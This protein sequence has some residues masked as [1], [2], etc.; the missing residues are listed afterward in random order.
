MM[1]SRL[2]ECCIVAQ[3]SQDDAGNETLKGHL[4]D[5]TKFTSDK[6][7]F[8]YAGCQVHWIICRYVQWSCSMYTV[9]GTF[10]K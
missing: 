6:R 8:S 1:Y 7:Q 4:M 5:N 10:A 3:F 9:V 2:C